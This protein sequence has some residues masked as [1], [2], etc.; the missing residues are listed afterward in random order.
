[1]RGHERKRE[2]GWSDRRWTG[3]KQIIFPP[4][5]G[6]PLWHQSTRAVKRIPFNSKFK[7]M[8]EC[9]RD[10]GQN[11]QDAGWSRAGKKGGEKKE[12]KNEE[13]ERGRRGRRRIV[14]EKLRVRYD[15]RFRLSSSNAH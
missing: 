9:Q 13:E 8:S 2:T 3:I 7:R 10:D 14:S 15:I 11:K 5:G 12:E 1:M 6:N 4:R